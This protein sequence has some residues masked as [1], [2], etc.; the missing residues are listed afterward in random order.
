MPRQRRFDG[1]SFKLA[2]SD[3]NHRQGFA[4]LVRSGYDI[5]VVELSKSGHD[6]KHWK[7]SASG[8]VVRIQLR[9]QGM[10]MRSLRGWRKMMMDAFLPV[11]F[12]NSVS[13]DYLAYQMYDSLQA[14]FSTI[15][16][17]LASRA[18]LQGLGVGDANS[19]ATFAM[20]LTIMR[21]AVSNVVT[22]IFAHRFGLSIEPEAKKYRFL[23]DLFNDSAFF[24]ELYSPHLG[25]WTKAIALCSA[26]GLRAVC[27]VAA[28]ASK[29]ALSLHFA[30]NDNLSELSAKEASQ[31][32][33]VSLVGL[34]V[35]TVVVRAV[36][37]HSL[38][39]YLVVALSLAHLWTNYRGV[40][41]VCMTSINKQRATILFYAYMSSSMVL[42]P[43]Q[44]A[45]SERIIFWDGLMRN[46][47]HEP[48]LL[49]SYAKNFGDAMSK[50][51]K[52]VVAVD[53][54]MHTSFI[55]PYAP[56]R[57]GNIKIL[58]W[59]GAEPKHAILAWFMAMDTARATTTDNPYGNNDEVSVAAKW[60]PRARDDL[61]WTNLEAQGW[62]LDTG[63]METGPGVRLSVEMSGRKDE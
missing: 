44:V 5:D 59:D 22:I 39:V 4:H 33:A 51:A 62:D 60:R 37:D 36:Q 15:T 43:Q 7:H 63:A 10:V 38:V 40:R 9:S 35:G 24:L 13:S 56:G 41:S 29:A 18:L 21:N 34:L 2:I 17:L 53:G 11:D 48:V 47:S 8:L 31:E 25:S 54:P 46:A 27:G 52:D 61:L 57:P 14:F 42:T 20:L 32:T 23:A 45:E 55:R 16:S 50:G 3:D 12:P 28:G 6:P 19:S 49:I 58:L 1:D 30:K 26:E